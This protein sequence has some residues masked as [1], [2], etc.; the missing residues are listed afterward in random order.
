MHII[1]CKI[2]YFETL[3]NKTFWTFHK[4]IKVQ[5]KFKSCI[6]RKKSAFGV[7]QNQLSIMLQTKFRL[8]MSRLWVRNMKIWLWKQVSFEELMHISAKGLFVERCK[9]IVLINNMAIEVN[10]QRNPRL[11]FT[12]SVTLWDGQISRC[13]YKDHLEQNSSRNFSIEISYPWENTYHSI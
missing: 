1:I 3:K 9:A 11:I 2:K 13:K 6:T 12:V 8:L 5:K 10:I 7:F 4:K